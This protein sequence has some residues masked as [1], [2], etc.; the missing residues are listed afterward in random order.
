ML[1]SIATILTSNSSLRQ[2]VGQRQRRDGALIHVEP[3]G[4]EHSRPIGPGT[5]E[6]RS[7]VYVYDY[8]YV[9]A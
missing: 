4:S 2:A 8:G 1:V 7:N 5:S 9:Y 3:S 6:L